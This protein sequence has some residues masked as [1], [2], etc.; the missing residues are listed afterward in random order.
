VSEFGNGGGRRNVRHE[1]HFRPLTE[2]VDD[3][4]EE[5]PIGGSGEVHVDAR[6]WALWLRPRLRWQSVRQLLSSCTL[7]TAP[8][9]LFYLV[10]HSGPVNV[11]SCECF[12]AT[13]TWMPH[14]KLSQDAAAKLGRDHNP[15]T[16][17]KT[18]INN[19]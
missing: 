19:R 6:P 1:K 18:A 15:I 17:E 7:E 3:D 13:D 2:G 8:T 11:T 5:L 10:V 16:K 12:H 14:M 4:E 9:Y